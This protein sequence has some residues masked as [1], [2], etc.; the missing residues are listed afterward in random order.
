MWIEDLPDG[1]YKFREQYKNPLTGKYNKVSVT[2]PKKTNATK[3]QAQIMLE[4][5]ITQKLRSIQDGNIKQGVTL[6]QVI[7]EWEPVYKKQVLSSTFYSWKTYKKQIKQRMRFDLLVNKIT[8]KYL[9]NLYED[10]MYKENYDKEFVSQLKSKVNHILKYAYQHDY[11]SSLP[12]ANLPINWPKKR[13]QSSIEAKFLEDDELQAVLKYVDAHNHTYKS[14]LEW[15]SLTGMRFG[16]AATMQIKNI[17]EENGKYYADVVG[18]MVYHGL[19]V[20]DHYKSPLTKTDSGR[21]TI[22]LPQRAVEIYKEFAR[23]KHKNDFLFQYKTNLIMLENINHLLAHAKK[24]LHINKTLSSHTM[25]HTHVSKLAELGVPL[26]I[27]QNRVGHSD[28]KITEQVY[29]HVTKKA[30]AKYDNLI[31]QM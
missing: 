1:K 22:F 12:S 10:M 7:K 8:P 9:I 30:K 15:Q 6:G 29:M 19:R 31:N 13:N 20:A 23:N 25:R 4:Q 18:T 27:I 21:R 24:K 26:Y 5:K 3:R 14:L 28:S 17:H 2:L 16:E 11:I